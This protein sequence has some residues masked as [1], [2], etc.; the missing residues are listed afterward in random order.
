MILGKDSRNLIDELKNFKGVKINKLY[1]LD[2]DSFVMDFIYPRYNSVSSLFYDTNSIVI[3][4]RIVDGIEKWKIIASSSMVSHIL[5]KLENTT[6]LIDFKEINLK[7]LERLLDKLTDRNLSF[8]KIAHK[9]GLFDYP[10][11]KTLLSL[12]KEL[13]IKPNTLLY[14]IRKSESSLLEI[15]IDEY[16]SLL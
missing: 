6:N 8:L 10:K 2:E 9:Q 15:L 3:S 12:S 16:Y 11:R 5:E 14:H 4:H 13:G 7:K 1:C